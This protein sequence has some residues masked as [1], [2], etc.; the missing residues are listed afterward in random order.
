MSLCE[1]EPERLLLEQLLRVGEPWIDGADLYVL[2]ADRSM[3]QVA[4]QYGVGRRRIDLAIF[5]ETRSLAVEVDGWEVH[6]STPV[7][8][9]DTCS[10][11]REVAGFGWTPIHFT[12][13]EINRDVVRCV[14]ELRALMSGPVLP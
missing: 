4:P 8:A 11:S 7:L 9:D 12:G 14:I 5:T 3:C 1:S 10:R 6:Y 13:G 2:A